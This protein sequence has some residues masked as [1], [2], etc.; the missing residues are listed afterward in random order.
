M[1]A[2]A[3]YTA[4]TAGEP[5]SNRRAVCDQ[6]SGARPNPNGASRPNQPVVRGS[7]R[8]MNARRT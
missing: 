8:S 5:V 6:S 1:P 3:A 4:G 2:R 7:R